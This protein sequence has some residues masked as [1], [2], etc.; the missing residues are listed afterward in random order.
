MERM[1]MVDGT[2]GRRMGEGGS[3]YGSSIS[4]VV[5]GGSCQRSLS[6]WHEDLRQSK[7]LN[8]K[9]RSTLS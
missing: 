1:R 5:V 7:S 4:A 8:S 9:Q 2:S 6:S 3:S